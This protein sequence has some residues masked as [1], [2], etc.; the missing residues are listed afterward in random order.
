MSSQDRKSARYARQLDVDVAG[1]EIVTTNVAA[2]GVQ[3]SCP[4]MRY[5][6]FKTAK[7]EDGALK[8]KIRLPG[9]QEWLTAEGQ[10]RYADLCEDEYLIGF[11]FTAWGDQHAANWSRYIETLSSA[12]P[13][14]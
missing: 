5:R 3:L 7:S 9:T 14:D 4:E 13:I 11:Q 8:F 12:K 10:V 6:G 1:I 2:G